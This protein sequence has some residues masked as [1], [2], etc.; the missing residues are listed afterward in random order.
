MFFELMPNFCCQVLGEPDQEPELRVRPG[1]VQHCGLL[2]LR[3][4]ADL[5]GR[6]QHLR[7]SAR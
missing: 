5:H 4:G 2:P 1:Q 7:P 3:G 6:L